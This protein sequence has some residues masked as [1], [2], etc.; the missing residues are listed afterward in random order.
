MLW[1]FPKPPAPARLLRAL[2]CGSYTVNR[3]GGPLVLQLRVSIGVA[4]FAPGDTTT[5][6]LDRADAAMYAGKGEARRRA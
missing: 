5:L 4:E 2:V 1:L 3:N 6:L